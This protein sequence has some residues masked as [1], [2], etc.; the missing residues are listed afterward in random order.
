M[1]ALRLLDESEAIERREYRGF[2]VGDQ[3]SHPGN[4]VGLL[5]LDEVP[6]DVEAR[7]GIRTLVRVNPRI[8][9]PAEQDIKDAGRAPEEGLRLLEI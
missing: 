6:D 2:A 8:R 3:V 1:L 7:P 9:K 4:P 5:R